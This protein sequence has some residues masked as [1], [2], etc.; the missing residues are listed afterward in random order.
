MQVGWFDGE[1]FL[2]DVR[3]AVQQFTSGCTKTAMAS[4]VHLDRYHSG[5][6]DLAGL[7]LAASHRFALSGTNSPATTGRAVAGEAA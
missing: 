5:L 4:C 2:L 6:L 1:C 7:R 3:Q